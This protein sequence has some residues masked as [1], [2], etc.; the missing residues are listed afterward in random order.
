MEK[1]LHPILL[2]TL[3]TLFVGCEPEKP[4]DNMFYLQGHRGARGLLPENTIAS[5]MQAISFGMNTLEMDVVVSKDKKIVVSHEPFFSSETCLDDSAQAIEPDRESMYNLYQMDYEAIKKFDCGSIPHPRFP[6]QQQ[7]PSYKP[8][9]SKVI[10]QIESYTE[11]NMLPA[12]LYN[13]EIK[14]T[15]EGDGIFHPSPD[16]FADLVLDIVFMHKI[17][18]RVFIQSFDVRP[19][20]YIH[21]EKPAI[22]L[23]LLVENPEGPEK[24]IE[25]LGF[26]PYAYSPEFIY[27]DD[28][29]MAWANKNNLLVIPWTVNS[30]DDMQKMISFGVN[31]IITDYPDRLKT[32]WFSKKKQDDIL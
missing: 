16:E 17:E 30:P 2:L 24:N 31:G 21:K 29:L 8:L 20:Q 5:F 26:T 32:V 9:L 23:A 22:R 27:V 7:L 25:K 13:I 10:E 6:E 15:P 1:T 19:L 4:N 28:A 14:C 3:A 18:S 11:A 12:M